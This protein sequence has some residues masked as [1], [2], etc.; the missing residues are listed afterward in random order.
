MKVC[1]TSKY[2]DSSFGGGNQF[3][4]NFVNYV[5]NLSIIDLVFDLSSDDIDIIFV[6][7]PRKLTLNKITMD[8]VKQYKIQHP[9]VKVIHRVNDCD[10]PRGNVDVLDPIL[11]KMFE[12]DDF[13]IF[14]SQWTANYFKAKGF[15]GKHAVINS[16]LI[17]NISFP[18]NKKKLTK[19]ILYIITHHWSFNYNKGFA[20]YNEMDKLLDKYPDIK[21][22][23]IGRKYNEKYTP[24]NIKVIG[25]YHGDELGNELRKGDIYISASNFENCP[26]HV[27]EGSAC[28]LPVVYH[29]NLGGGVEICSNHGEEFSTAQE[30]LDKIQIIRK[31]YQDYKSKINYQKVSSDYCNEI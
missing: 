16:D 3:V 2:I 25:P 10:K 17:L 15:K 24:K 20:I 28:G 23:Y 14:V 5:N 13:V 26:M 12:I 4:Q 22:T 1:L 27:I 18:L 29:K 6:I 7:D 19:I 9:N 31:N 11:F 8:M 30:C 21:F